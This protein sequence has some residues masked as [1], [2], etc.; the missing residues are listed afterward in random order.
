MSEIT[1]AFKAQRL[2]C[3]AEAGGDLRRLLTG[4]A[5]GR[6][7]KGLPG[8]APE[9]PAAARLL[10]LFFLLA[11]WAHSG[12]SG[13][14]WF[15]ETLWRRLGLRAPGPVSTPGPVSQPLPARR[16]M[17][18]LMSACAALA[19]GSEDALTWREGA[20][21]V[22]PAE[23]LALRAA[24]SATRFSDI[25]PEN[26]TEIIASVVQVAVLPAMDCRFCWPGAQRARRP[27][28]ALLPPTSPVGPASRFPG[29][30]A[31]K[32]TQLPQLAPAKPPPGEPEDREP[33]LGG[34]P[35]ASARAPSSSPHPP[36][37][38]A[39]GRWEKGSRLSRSFPA[40][41]QV[42]R[43]G[44]GQSASGIVR[45]PGLRPRP[46][47]RLRPLSHSLQA[48]TGRNRLEGRTSACSRRPA[49]PGFKGRGPPRPTSGVQAPQVRPAPTLPRTLVGPGSPEPLGPRPGARGPPPTV[50]MAPGEAEARKGPARETSTQLP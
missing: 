44:R 48:L 7:R 15:S 50:A 27:R 14:V 38:G 34:A 36:A 18:D 5:G 24:G 35:R 40:A 30:R 19:G 17:V 47:L 13:R 26:A 31:S 28:F 1:I 6:A 37:A 4:R 41:K 22:D 23:C 29:T 10:L 11:H 12:Q 25:T 21:G 45:L 33:G 46:R 20:K 49:H 43:V 42:P 16:R 3:S 8:A 2:G 32:G 39:Q 9:P